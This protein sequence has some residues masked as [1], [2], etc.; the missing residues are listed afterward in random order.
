[1][2]RILIFAGHLVVSGLLLALV[3]FPYWESYG[4]YVVQAGGKSIS[5]PG[6]LGRYVYATLI[7]WLCTGPLAYA[8][9]ERIRPEWPIRTRVSWS[10][11]AGFAALVAVA[12][13]MGTNLL[14]A[15][16]VHRPQFVKWMDLFLAEFRFIAFLG[17]SFLLALTSI[18]TQYFLR[19]A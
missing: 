19:R 7:A 16:R 12:F 1:M 3:V 13:L 11:I 5:A 2:V 17:Y 10:V 4:Y 18:L 14:F 6:L 8:L 15:D 9:V